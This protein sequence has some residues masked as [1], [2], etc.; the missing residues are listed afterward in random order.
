MVV[1]IWLFIY[2][3]FTFS[4]THRAIPRALFYMGAYT[5]HIW[6]FIY[7]HPYMGNFKII[8]GYTYKGTH[9]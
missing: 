2:G 3:Y 9:I 1:H 5:V 8:Y 6:L 7:G 4:L